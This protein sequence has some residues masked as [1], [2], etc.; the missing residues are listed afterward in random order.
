MATPKKTGLQIIRENHKAKRLAVLKEI[1]DAGPEGTRVL[2]S[3][4]QAHALDLFEQGFVDCNDDGDR[5]V[6]RAPVAARAALEAPP[7][8]RVSPVVTHVR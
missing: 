5:W 1:L 8:V 7:E 6:I 3:E 2:G 4:A